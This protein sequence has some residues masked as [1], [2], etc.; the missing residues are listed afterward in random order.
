[1]SKKNIPHP[2]H[3]HPPKVLMIRNT[4][5]IDKTSKFEPPYLFLAPFFF[6]LPFLLLRL[7]SYLLLYL[8]LHI[9]LTLLFK[10]SR[11]DFLCS[12]S[13]GP[14]LC[15]SRSHSFFNSLSLSLSTSPTLYLSHSFI[16]YISLYLS[17]SVSLTLC[18]SHS[19]YLSLV[20]SP[21]SRS[22]SVFH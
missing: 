16:H 9:F 17:L 2:A 13:H 12:I 6:P 3:P 19:L 21:D 10:H 15:L 20:L 4:H 18:I 14:C 1:M 7:S 8:L 22:V 5:N 11:I